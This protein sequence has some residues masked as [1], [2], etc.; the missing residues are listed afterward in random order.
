MLLST[1]AEKR[2]SMPEA[3]KRI[4]IEGPS[5]YLEGLSDYNSDP[6]LSSRTNTP[7]ER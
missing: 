2:V 5:D 7:N 1:V 3:H 6:T 4:F